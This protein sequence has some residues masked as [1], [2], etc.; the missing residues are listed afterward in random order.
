MTHE[1]RSR[2]QEKHPGLPE[3]PHPG[4][5]PKQSQRQVCGKSWFVPFL[6]PSFPSTFPMI[7]LCC[8]VFLRWL[9]A[10]H[11]TTNA[12]TACDGPSVDPR[13]MMPH[14]ATTQ[15]WSSPKP[16]KLNLIRVWR[17]CREVCPLLHLHL[18]TGGRHHRSAAPHPG[19]T[20]PLL[21]LL[22]LHPQS[23]RG[24]GGAPHP[25]LQG[26][27]WRGGAP[28]PPPQ[29]PSSPCKAHGASKDKYK[30]GS[31]NVAL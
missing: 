2:P 12:Y 16:T 6:L 26:D 11:L 21:L 17:E 10:L 27:R 23:T 20:P 28:P 3:P 13:Y 30:L 7:P 19:Y 9:R 8:A 22:P 5:I 29:V 4:N 18:S 24:V 31:Q 1:V 15:P 14:D 25:L